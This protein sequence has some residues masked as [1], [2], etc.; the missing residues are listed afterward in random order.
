MH[1]RKIRTN[2]VILCLA[3]TH[4]DLRLGSG[5]FL[6]MPPLW[7]DTKILLSCSVIIS[8]SMTKRKIRAKQEKI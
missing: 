5:H 7:S 4:S 3:Q 1:Q 6:D 2:Q 8:P